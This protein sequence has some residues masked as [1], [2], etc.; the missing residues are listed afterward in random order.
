M[1]DVNNGETISPRRIYVDHLRDGKLAYQFSTV[2]QR[3]VFYPRVRCPFTGDDC[4]EWRISM[5]LGTIYSISVVYPRKEAAYNV[6]L[7]DIDE[8]FR[9]MSKVMTNEPE[10]VRIG[11]RVALRV[12]SEAGLEDPIPVF[13]IVDEQS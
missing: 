2:A 13:D 12:V 7:I 11:Q 3:A 10:S 1:T 9:M 6:A 5:G 8:G 4:L